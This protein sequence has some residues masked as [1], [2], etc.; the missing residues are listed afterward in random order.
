[1]CLN[2]LYKLFTRLLGKFMRNHAIENNIWNEGRLG[3]AR[4]VLGTV[5]QLI[6]DRYMMEEVKNQHRNLALASCHYKKAN[7]KVHHD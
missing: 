3:A 7:D 5:Y 1:M 6:I 2:I 4:G